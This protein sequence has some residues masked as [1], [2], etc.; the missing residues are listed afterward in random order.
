MQIAHRR[1]AAHVENTGADDKHTQT[2]PTTMATKTNKH[3]NTSICV[4]DQGKYRYANQIANTN[5]TGPDGTAATSMLQREIASKRLVTKNKQPNATQLTRTQRTNVQN[6]P[7][8]HVQPGNDHT[9]THSHIYLKKWSNQML[10]T[11]TPVLAAL[12]LYPYT[13]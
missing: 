11:N 13:S 8:A 12:L 6:V 7:T 10:R 2:R 9:N 3:L 1:E 5:R 4:C